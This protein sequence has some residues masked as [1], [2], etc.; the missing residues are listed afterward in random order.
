MV[1]TEFSPSLST[2]DIAIPPNEFPDL[3]HPD[4]VASN[5][6]KVDSS[7][8]FIFDVPL[9]ATNAP[10][11]LSITPTPLRRS[12]RPYN[13]PTYLHDYHCNLV[14][15]HV[16]ALASLTQSH[17]SSATSNSGILYP[18]SS[19][20]SY[21]KLFTPLRLF[22]VALSVTKEPNSYAQALKDPLW[23]VAMK[24]EIDALQANHTWVM[25]KLPPG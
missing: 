6:D 14:F 24:A 9:L 1:S 3:V 7:P 18:L 12:N 22:Y 5:A 15:A 23:Q 8:T 16:L 17:G 11:L 25:T 4:Q 2:D 10:A 20:L 19:T 21:S 13:P